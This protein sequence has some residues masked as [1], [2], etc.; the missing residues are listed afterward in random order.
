MPG[1]VLIG[2]PL[3]WTLVGVLFLAGMLAAYVAF[4]AVRRAWFP[5]TRAPE[6]VRWWF[7]VPQAAYLV[8]VLLGQF[9]A[10]PMAVTGIVVLCTPLALGQ[11]VVYLLRVVFPKPSAVEIGS[12]AEGE[13]VPG[14]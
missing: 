3:F 11:Q 9:N 10:I 12:P 1:R 13:V 8:L 7:L 5:G 2:G 4:D 14:D 6:R